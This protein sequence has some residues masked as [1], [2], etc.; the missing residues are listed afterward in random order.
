MKQQLV[1]YRRGHK[2]ESLDQFERSFDV[3]EITE[4]EVVWSSNRKSIEFIT[5]SM[6]SF[7]SFFDCLS[8][9]LRPFQCSFLPCIN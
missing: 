5:V 1:P 2:L 4:L 8:T 6:S 7:T 9:Q 3:V